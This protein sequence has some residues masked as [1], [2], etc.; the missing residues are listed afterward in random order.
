MG[1]L[2]EYAADTN[3]HMI[4][5]SLSLLGVPSSVFALTVSQRTRKHGKRFSLSL[6]LLDLYGTLRPLS[7]NLPQPGS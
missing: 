3:R 5:S 6:G 2:Y 7:L 1:S 4:R